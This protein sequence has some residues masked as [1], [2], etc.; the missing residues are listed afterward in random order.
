MIDLL[1]SVPERFWPHIEV[2]MRV[3]FI[4]AFAAVFVLMTRRVVNRLRAHFVRLSQ[5]ADG[6]PEIQRRAK[7][8]EGVIQTVL[9]VIIVAIAIAMSLR[10][11]GFDI[12]PLLAG[13]G[14]AGIAVGL[15]SQHIFKDLLN[16]FFMLVDD[17]VRVG[18]TAVINGTGGV[19]EH[20]NLRTT[21]LR[22]GEGSLHFFQ[23]GNIGSLANKT[24][25]YSNY[26][27]Q[28]GI[29]YGSDVDK[30]MQILRDLGKDLQSSE[31]GDVIL[32]PFE[33]WGVD[34]F[35]DAGVVIK[36]ALRTR[37]GK[38]WGVGREMNRRIKVAFDAAGIEFQGKTT[39]LQAPVEEAKVPSATGKT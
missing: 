13:A 17:Q 12:G 16:G 4:L 14:V 7:T 21:V 24:R 39:V 22:D 29:A 6:T 28:I 27:F 15:G 33:V 8:L 5:T 25:D 1:A 10:E 32:K 18:E 30:A 34:Q 36:G 3:V 26:L 35:G 2:G 31:Y 37:P 23:N 11:M 38:Q 9:S 19:V 20:L